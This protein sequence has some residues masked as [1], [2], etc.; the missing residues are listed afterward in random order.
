[1]SANKRC[2]SSANGEFDTLHRTV[3]ATESCER[4]A[5]S[6]LPLLSPFKEFWNSGSLSRI[7][8]NSDTSDTNAARLLESA[9]SK[10]IPSTEL[11][12]IQGETGRE[13]RGAVASGGGV[14]GGEVLCESGEENT[15][16]DPSLADSRCKSSNAYLGYALKTPD[17]QD[18]PPPRQCR[19]PAATF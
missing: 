10:E 17:S 9:G 3:S 11:P 15:T 13:Q 7:S 12:N 5:N 18:L 8:P 19:V 4:P 14:G 6:G 16:T 1:M 2:V